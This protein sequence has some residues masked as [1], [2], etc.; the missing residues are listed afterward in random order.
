[1]MCYFKGEMLRNLMLWIHIIFLQID[2]SVY[3]EI[4]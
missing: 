1:M 3:S 4:Y 2:V